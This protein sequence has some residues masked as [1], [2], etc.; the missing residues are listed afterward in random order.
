LRYMSRRTR[1]AGR[2]VTAQ[3]HHM[4]MQLEVP[5]W[6]IRVSASGEVTQQVADI[7]QVVQVKDRV[8]RRMDCIV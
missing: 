5:A 4:C 2:C 6:A 3:S 8:C 1:S 7:S